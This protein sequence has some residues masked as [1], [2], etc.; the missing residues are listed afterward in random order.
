[1]KSTVIACYIKQYGARGLRVFHTGFSYLQAGKFIKM[2]ESYI[3]RKG[4]F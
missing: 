2:L 3:N 4:A 1:M